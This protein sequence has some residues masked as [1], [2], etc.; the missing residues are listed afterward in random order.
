MS[1]ERKMEGTLAYSEHEEE[2]VYRTVRCDTDGYT[3]VIP[4]GKYR[5][6]LKFSEIEHDAVGKRVFE[7]AVHNQSIVTNLDVFAEVGKD[8]AYQV[9]SPRMD[10]LDGEFPITFVR[11]KGSPCISAISIGGTTVDGRAFYQHVN[12]GGPDFRGYY[13]DYR[14]LRIAEPSTGE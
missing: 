6:V 3:F 10:V 14:R 11:E 8:R 2:E 9:L 1:T 5:A 13:A 7:V 4:N 12:C